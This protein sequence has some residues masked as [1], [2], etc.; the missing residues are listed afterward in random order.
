MK[1]AIRESIAFDLGEYILRDSGCVEGDRAGVEGA[2][3]MG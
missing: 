2:G 3:T 1:T